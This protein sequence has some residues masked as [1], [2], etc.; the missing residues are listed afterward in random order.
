MLDILRFYFYDDDKRRYNI[1]IDYR[2]N[3]DKK[4]NSSR[5]S[6]KVISRKRFERFGIKIE[7]TRGMEN[8]KLD[9]NILNSKNISYLNKIKK[10]INKE[11]ENRNN[12][13]NRIMRAIHWYSQGLQEMK[14]ETEL[15]NYVMALENLLHFGNRG[16]HKHLA[17]NSALI[18]KT[19]GYED[20]VKEFI[21]KEIYVKRSKVVH[22]DAYENCNI[23]ILR[24]ITYNCI[25][26]ILKKCTRFMNSSNPAEEF[27]KIVFKKKRASEK[28]MIFKSVSM[29]KNTS[30]HN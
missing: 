9:Q 11:K 25:M 8:L 14:E 26:Y 10:I 17:E 23:T 21:D 15:I 30:I 13:E 3:K 19:L 27:N 29:L 24:H 5:N 16:S 1:Q 6:K 4:D 20:E 2:I 18:H 7:I 28:T 12:L 22:G